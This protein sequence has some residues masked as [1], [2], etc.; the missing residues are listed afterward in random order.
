MYKRQRTVRVGGCK[1]RYLL[2]MAAAPCVV[3]AQSTTPDSAV[4]EVVVTGIRASIQSSI[5]AKRE[6]SVVSDV[7]SAEDI[8]DL[9]ALSIGEAI[10]TITGAATHR[11]KGGAS[12]IAVRGLGPFLGATTFNGREATNGSGDRSVNFSMFPSEL[13]NGVAIYKSQQADFVEGGVAGIIDMQ[14]V[15]PLSFGR[16]RLQGE[17]RG[18]YQGYDDRLV[19]DNG[20]GW[21]GT[22]NYIDQFELGSLGEIGVSVGVQRGQSSNPE[23]MYSTSST[24]VACRGDTPAPLNGNCAQVTPDDYAS[25]AVPAGTPYYLTTGSRAFTQFNE[26]DDR[27]AAFV[28]VEWQPLDNVVVNLDY[29]NSTN[30]FTER[31][32]TLNLSE[33][34]R[35]YGDSAVFDERGVLLSYSGESPLESTPLYRNQ[36]EEY[37][38]GGLNVAWDV[39]DRISVALDYGVSDTYRSRMDREVR[40]RTS[41]RDIYG[42]PVAGIRGQRWVGYTYD[43]TSG[44]F[45][46]I[47][48]DPDFD[49]ND[50]DNFSADARLRRTEQVRN[51]EI[52]AG[53]LDFTFQVA[54]SGITQL[55]VG[56]RLAEHKFWD[57]NQDRREI[58]ISDRAEI[59]AANLACRNS[60]FPQDDFLSDTDGGQP[61]SSW[62]TFDALCLFNNFLGTQDPG[63]TDDTRDIA[64]RDVT[65]D[66][67]AAYVMATFATDFGSIPLSGNFGVRYVDTDVTSLG[68]R[69]ALN[70]IN[71][72][73]GTIRLEETG[74]FLTLRQKGGSEKWL[75]S[76]NLA[77]DMSDRMRLR[78]G[79][80]RAMSRPDP[81]DLGAGRIFTFDDSV[82]YGS[83]AEAVREIRSTGNP[84]LQPLMSWN[85]DLSAEYYLNR[86]SLFSAGLFYKQFQGGFENIVVN[87]TYDIGGE[88]I[89]VPV[90]LTR[91]SDDESEIY[92]IELTGSYRFSM[93]PAPFDGFGVKASYSYA[94][95]T[96]ETEDLRLGDQ[97]DAATGAIAPGLIDPV[98]IFGLSKHVA[99]GS[100]Y[101]EIGPVELQLIGKYRSS[102]YQQFV[103]AAS[104]NRVVRD[105]T[106]IDFR[107][108][109]R[110]TDGLS[111]SFQGSNLNNEER[112]EDMPIP[113]SVREVHVYGPRYYLGAR[114]RF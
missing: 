111:L 98:D 30:E 79:L 59:A 90:T 5:E 72:P 109:Y 20:L 91:T 39:T 18:I 84:A 13:I 67:K 104:Q 68:L 42:Q 114:Y 71:N 11:E 21:R 92:G 3:Q 65:E 38:G 57:I 102:Y 34:M 43:A 61:I 100:L 101:Y 24:W 27:E 62:A 73:D 40:L 89:T 58:S 97:Q 70:V 113:G 49:V 32:N 103:G 29:Q 85:V 31:R 64:N 76:F 23:E 83:V 93:L 105:A 60:R 99:S 19:D 14:T 15:R 25:G 106:V 66:S 88:S 108:S 4:E 48:L 46:S 87:E 54:D 33:T 9:P 95:S 51:D 35:G 110:L 94:E 47:T 17:V 69:S 44:Y 37:E 63:R 80:F 50:A 96:F 53:R 86:D 74:D 1:V 55:Q 36:I 81:E 75:P 52:E 77:A 45:P 56:A 10:E 26:T 107:A 22:L 8:G 78:L 6:A 112:V 28:A 12:E 82:S 2:L 16:Q 7:L 41:N